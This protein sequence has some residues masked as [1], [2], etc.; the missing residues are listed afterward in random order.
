MPFRPGQSGN[1]AGK[2]KGIKSKTSEEIRGMFQTFLEQN[3]E[4]LQADYDQLE[5]KERLSFIEKI[6]RLILPPALNLENL[7]ESQLDQLIE[8][9]KSNEQ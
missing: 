7:S 2:P 6:A 9:L 1:P 4:N 3:I 8:K 5:S